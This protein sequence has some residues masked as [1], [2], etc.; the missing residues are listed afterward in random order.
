MAPRAGRGARLR[1]GVR[2][3]AGA[4]ELPRRR[5]ARGGLLAGVA[6]EES[7]REHC[8][9]VDALGVRD[10]V[11]V[12]RP[13]RGDCHDNAGPTDEVRTTRV[14]EAPTG[15]RL[16]LQEGVGLAARTLDVGCHALTEAGVDRHR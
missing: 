5:A 4:L 9:R 6:A 2:G 11:A 16:E 8:G 13:A 12:L 15:T 10:A 7:R 14:T 3:A 1:L